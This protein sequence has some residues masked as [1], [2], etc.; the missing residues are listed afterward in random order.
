MFIFGNNYA[1][2]F[3][4]NSAY[5]LYLFRLFLELSLLCETIF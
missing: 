2:I 5:I 3:G 4:L 1:S